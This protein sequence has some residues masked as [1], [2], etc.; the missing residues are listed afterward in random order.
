MGACEEPE[1]EAWGCFLEGQ[2]DPCVLQPWTWYNVG[3]G[4]TGTWRTQVIWSLEK[5]VGPGIGNMQDVKQVLLQFSSR[6][7]KSVTRFFFW[8]AHFI[9]GLMSMLHLLLVSAILLIR[10]T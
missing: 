4:C 1:V 9:V 10:C 6:L 5:L 2:F 7:S 3:T 8:N